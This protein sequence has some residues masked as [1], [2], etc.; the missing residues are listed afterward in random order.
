MPLFRPG[1]GR[2]C[3]MTVL[4]WITD[5]TWAAC[6][7]AARRLA[8]ADQGITLLHVTDSAAAD[9][10]RGAFTGL[11]G[12]AGRDPG[13]QLEAMADSA[14]T[15]LLDAAAARLGRAADRVRRHGRPEHQV[16]EAAR[17]A[18]LLVVAREGAEAG[19]KSLGKA[20]RFV[21]DHAPCPVLLI[22]PGP[23]PEGPPV[24]RRPP[25]RGGHGPRHRDG[26]QHHDRG[27]TPGGSAGMESA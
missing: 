17:G 10:A 1:R 15:E 12:R 24:P 4:V 22:W 25:H 3:V 18:S 26:P 11:L 14:A 23:V 13:A 2:L 21:V 8:P 6:V 16:T 27:G 9:A 20:A 5:D 7:D 19:P